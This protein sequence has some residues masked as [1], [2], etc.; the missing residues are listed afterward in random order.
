[1]FSVEMDKTTSSI[2]VIDDHNDYPEVEMIIGDA[3]VFIRQYDEKRDE[4]DVVRISNVMLA[5]L[6]LAMEKEEGNYKT[7]LN[8]GTKHK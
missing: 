5:E 8:H 4:H 3:E 7:E 1:M 6:L 2:T